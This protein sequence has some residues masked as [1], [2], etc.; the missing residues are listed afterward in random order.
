L[1]GLPRHGVADVGDDRAVGRLP[2]AGGV[3]IDDMDRFRPLGHKSPGLGDRVGPVHGLTVV[4]TLVETNTLAVAE[5][6]GWKQD[7]DVG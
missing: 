1:N 4:V 3:E 6:D 5:I 7:H 2:G